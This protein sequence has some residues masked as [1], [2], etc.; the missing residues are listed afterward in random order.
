MRVLFVCSLTLVL[1]ACA[2]KRC[3]QCKTESIP[4]KLEARSGTKTEGELNIRET[5]DGGL[6]IVGQVRSLAPGAHGFHVHEFGD[7]SAPDASSA[8]DHFRQAGQIHAG[9]LHQRSHIG[10]LGNIRANEE[11]IANI[12]ITSNELCLSRP[13][14]SVFGRAFVV[15]A[16]P[17]DLRSQPSGNSGARVACGAVKMKKCCEQTQ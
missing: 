11:G 5:A 3:I 15:H 7:C 10:D 14:C 12:Q 4:V 16:D 6:S 17:D 8:G 1:S 9:P 13:E 2:S